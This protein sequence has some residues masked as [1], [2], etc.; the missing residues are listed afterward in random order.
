MNI[1]ELFSGV[2]L[3]I[4]DKVN[5]TN[6]EDRITK[7][8]DLLENKNIPLIKRNS[9]PNQEI[10][11]HCK[12]LNFIL[13][14]WEL[15]SLTSEDGM[16]LPNSQVIEKE[17][18][19]CI[20]DF[21][22]KILDKCFLPIFI[23]SNKA[24]ESIINI[25]KEKRVI[26][27]NI[28]RPIFV[29][30]KSDIVIDNNVLVFQKI[31]EWINAMPSIYV[32]KE[33][34]RAF[35]NAKTN[36]FKDLLAGDVHWPQVLW[37][38]SALDGVNAN[39]EL[40]QVLTQNIL[41]RMQ[42]VQFEKDKIIK[43][44]IQCE[45]LKVQTILKAQRFTENIDIESSNTGDFFDINGQCKINIRPACDCVGRN[46]MKKVYLINCQPFNPKIDF[47]AQYG[48][49]SERNNEAKT[50]PLYK[51]KFYT[52]SFKEMEIAEYN[53]IKQY[54]K[55]R[56]LMP[57]ITY[58]TEKYSLYI[59]RQGLPR[60]PKIAIPNYEEQKEDDN[61]KELEVLKAE[62][63]KLQEQNKDLLKQE[64]I[65]KSCRT[66]IRYVQRGRKRKKK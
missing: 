6:G 41:A 48:N 14:D 52:F 59:Q 31:E 33:W 64:V 57:F 54:K 34:D 7:I 49:F 35:L 4:D 47:Q 23:F 65:T 20:V 11:E 18:E 19:N 10:L 5:V 66:T 60:I 55:G 24:E 56:I 61:D 2:G 13:L 39:E 9:I 53:D 32:L 29:K 28:S 12:N 62:N 27:D 30:S 17:N 63:L 50:G 40:A 38:T 25:L 1:E 43:D 16:P 44:N 46:G 15:Y 36:L 37:E 42:P 3:V 45:T 58:I 22:K 8:V 21:L 51:N 26:K